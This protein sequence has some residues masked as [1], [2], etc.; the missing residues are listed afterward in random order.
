MSLF[1]QFEVYDGLEIGDCRLS[2]SSRKYRIV[3]AI[4]HLALSLLETEEGRDS[5]TEVAKSIIRARNATRG[6]R[7]RRPHHIYT[8]S[9]DNMHRWIERFLRSMRQ[10]FP[11]VVICGT[12][13]EA[14]ADKVHWGDDMAAYIASDAG[15]L[16]VSAG[17][18]DN[19][20]NTLSQRSTRLRS[21]DD[22][23]IAVDV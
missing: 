17:I 19:M 2:P 22:E 11:P 10:G 1:G 13:G 4:V 16:H 8:D 5:L 14:A 18:I 7:S 20:V 6:S 15:A 21:D 3:E 23:E 12:K 9:L